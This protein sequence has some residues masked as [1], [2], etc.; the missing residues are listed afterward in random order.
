M[1][2]LAI[3]SLGRRLQK[4]LEIEDEKRRESAQ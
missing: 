1:H 2:I 4:Y 3:K